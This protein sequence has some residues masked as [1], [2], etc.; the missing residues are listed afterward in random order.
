MSIMSQILPVNIANVE[1]LTKGTRDLG[2]GTNEFGAN[3][4]LSQ[5]GAHGKVS[6]AGDHGNGSGDVVEEAMCARLGERESDEGDTRQG[7]HGADGL[8]RSA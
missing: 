6:D 3:A 7:H 2:V 5:V 8:Q 4:R 1:D